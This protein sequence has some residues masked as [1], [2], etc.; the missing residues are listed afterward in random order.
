MNPLGR[1]PRGALA[2]MALV[3]AL[4]AAA[5]GVV[6]LGTRRVPEAS[7][8]STQTQTDVDTLT[9]EPALGIVVDRNMRVV[10]IE[11]GST[12]QRIGIQRNDVVTAIQ[13]TQLSSAE[14]AR[15]IVRQAKV[16]QRLSIDI[17]RGNQSFTLNATMAP[18]VGH[19]HQATPTPVP[20]NQEYF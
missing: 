13:G 12:A 19:P 15:R 11:A 16:G 17:R 10:D 6:A 5:I 4:S 8:T 18:E 14:S 9:A 2:G 3:L 20:S 1:I 7:S